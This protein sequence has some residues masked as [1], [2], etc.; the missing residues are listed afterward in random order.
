MTTLDILVIC[1]DCGQTIPTSGLSA[2]PQPSS[3]NRPTGKGRNAPEAATGRTALESEI[4]KGG[5]G[6]NQVVEGAYVE[7]LAGGT[8]RAVPSQPHWK[9]CPSPRAMQRRI[10]S[11]IEPG[12]MPITFSRIKRWE[13]CAFGEQQENRIEN[14]IRTTSVPANVGTA[15]H[16]IAQA[17]QA[18]ETVDDAEL[19]KLVP[20]DK[21]EDF[22]YLRRSAEK[23]VITD[24]REHVLL[25]EDD[26]RLH[27]EFPV[28]TADGSQVIAQ[29][30]IKPDVLKIFT[31]ESLAEV[32]DYKTGRVVSN[33]VEDDD[34]GQLYCAV[35]TETDL[36]RDIQWF[37]FIQPQ[38]RFWDKAPEVRWSRAQIDAFKTRF[39]AKVQLYALEEEFR[40]RPGNWC[41]WCSV[42]FRCPEGKKLAATRIK[43]VKIETT[44][45][46]L[47][48]IDGDEQARL[49]AQTV[50]QMEAAVKQMNSWLRE[51]VRRTEKNI[52]MGDGTDYG[53]QIKSSLKLPRGEVERTRED[54][55]TAKVEVYEWAREILAE[56]GFNFDDYVRFDM[57]DGDGWKFIKGKR[58]PEAGL[59][60]DL[61]RAE[62]Y[63]RWELSKK[64]EDK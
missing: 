5:I 4:R 61:A 39:M 52:D 32:V 59:L 55:T 62:T 58:G 60:K 1:P 30:E 11:G 18:G 47:P 46:V 21:A 53:V 41:H 56:H 57:N 49:I 36:G 29:V 54:G 48:I 20:L 14:R 25:L 19:T 35:L 45:G 40:T 13:E 12:Y 63:T 22:A 50:V 28:Y 10:R 64:E 15:V 16:L 7:Q 8:I 9:V 34:Q 31:Q 6:H 38:L 27:W 43:G 24:K 51:H 3:T 37:D 33:N 42:A 44:E 17:R 2:S 23:L 26:A